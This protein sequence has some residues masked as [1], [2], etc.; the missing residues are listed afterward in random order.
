[1]QFSLAA[2]AALK[3]RYILACQLLLMA[4]VVAAL[5]IAVAGVARLDLVGPH[6]SSPV[7]QPSPAITPTHHG[8]N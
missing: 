6:V 4:I 1:M 5:M 8:A 7:Q 3:Q 2:S